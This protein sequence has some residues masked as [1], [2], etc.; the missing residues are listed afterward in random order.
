MS[1]PITRHAPLFNMIQL[2]RSRLAWCLTA[3]WLLSWLALLWL[4]Q[5]RHFRL[6][7]IDSGLRKELQSVRQE[8]A[9]VHNRHYLQELMKDRAAAWNISWLSCP[10]HQH[11]VL[12]SMDHPNDY[13]CMAGRSRWLREDPS[14]CLAFPSLLAPDS[15]VVFVG[16]GRTLGSCAFAA[17][18]HSMHVRVLDAANNTAALFEKNLNRQ[19][20][21]TDLL[22]YLTLERVAMGSARGTGYLLHTTL[23]NTLLLLPPTWDFK[24]GKKPS[25]RPGVQMLDTLV[26]AAAALVF[27]CAGCEL[28]ALQG[29]KK[30]VEKVGVKVLVINFWPRAYALLHQR[31]ATLLTQLHAQG[32]IIATRPP[33]KPM[34]TFGSGW[35][36]ICPQHFST[37]VRGLHNASALLVSAQASASWRVFGSAPPA[38][39]PNSPA[40][41]LGGGKL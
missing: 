39:P 33:V 28:G 26:P 40:L 37:F 3:L 31:G 34:P 13:L 18:S 22:R 4:D 14:F 35:A 8:I 20:F 30:L 5:S 6:D 11:P 25:L 41:A 9:Q 24:G 29:A 15:S 21:K 10:Q 2:P 23:E 12:Y 19:S 36:R 38:C 32:Y 16:F 1:F 27:D 17:A 7:R